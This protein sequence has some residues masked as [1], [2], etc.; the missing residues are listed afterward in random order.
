MPWIEGQRWKIIDE[1][2]E[3]WRFGLPK[4]ESEAKSVRQIRIRYSD[5]EEKSSHPFMRHWIILLNLGQIRLGSDNEGHLERI[6]IDTGANCNTITR[7]FYSILL[8]QGLK[9]AFYP[10]D[11]EI[12]LVGGQRLRVS[13]DKADVYDWS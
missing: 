9:C 6:V 2:A 3:N 8:D 10:G 1:S 13:G 5:I 7:K 11:I 4:P 12:N